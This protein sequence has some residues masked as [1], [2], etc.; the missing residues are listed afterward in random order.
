MKH[1]S[2]DISRRL[3]KIGG[4]LGVEREDIDRLEKIPSNKDMTNLDVGSPQDPIDAYKGP[5][6]PYYGT[7]SVN[8][9]Q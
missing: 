9:F 8:D 3:L 2:N 5:S 4:M 7:I 6:G 1:V